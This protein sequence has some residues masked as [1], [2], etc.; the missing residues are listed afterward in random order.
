[1][2]PTYK[3]AEKYRQDAHEKESQINDLKFQLAAA[4]ASQSKGVGAAGDDAA[5]WKQK[6]EKLL[7]NI[8]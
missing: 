5:Y 1:M 6:Y 8:D 2:I 7:S 3:A 4:K